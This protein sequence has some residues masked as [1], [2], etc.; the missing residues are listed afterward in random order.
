MKSISLFF[1]K[2]NCIETVGKLLL[3]LNVKVTNTTLQNDLYNHPDYPSLLSISDVLSGY[4]VANISV[5]TSIDKLTEV[6]LPCIIPLNGESDHNTYFAL[7]ESV[8]DN[9][10]RYFHPEK[11][12]WEEISKE[13]FKKK[14]PSGIVLLA[15]AADA[16]GEK[17]YKSKRREERRLNI[18]GYA[19]WLALPILTIITCIITFATYGLAAGFP[20][21]FMLFTLLGCGVSGLLLWYELDQYNP[22][23]QQICSSGKKVN[24]GAI[25]NSKASKIAG[26]SWSAIGFTYFSGSLFSMLVM[27]A[28]N[29]GALV[30]LA[31]LNTLAIPYV[32]FSVYYQWQIAKQWCVLCLCIQALLVLQLI[33]TTTAGWHTIAPLSTVATLSNS[34]P[35]VLSFATPF[36]ILNLLLPAY[37]AVRGNKRTKTQLQRLKHNPL[38]FEA[39]LVKQKS[40]TESTKGLGIILGN[41]NATNKIIKVCNPYCGPCAQA[42]TPMEELLHNNPD[43]Q[44]QILFTATNDEGD[45][46]APSVKHLL[47]IAEKGETLTRQALDDWYLADKKDYEVFAAKYPMNGELKKQDNKVNAM[48]EWCDKTEIA[49]T[50]TFFVN[51]YQLPD[52]YTVNDLKY[53]LSV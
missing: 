12:E 53:F 6:P 42:H 16:V 52:I 1:A 8:D 3:A 11:H 27:G 40:I 25:L 45:T 2:E 36:I 22:L 34:V 20:V 10:V 17:D 9:A 21:I 28:T 23:L 51:G 32:F 24:C 44:I 4:G 47:A 7:V 37:R 39:L 18:A 30:A 14:W 43:L 29:P 35:V 38:I 26:V 13:N 31:W 5:K 19:T 15:D 49:F 50:P 48:K 41:P 33:T 46:R